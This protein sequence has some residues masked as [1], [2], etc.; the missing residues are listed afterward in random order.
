LH[1]FRRAFCLAQLQAGV[2]ETTIARLMGHTST[3]LITRYA[4]QTAGDMHL[5]YR[6]PADGAE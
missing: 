2:P 4:Q 6:S 3:Q 1:D 5:L